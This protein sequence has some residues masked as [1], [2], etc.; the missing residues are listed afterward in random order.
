MWLYIPHKTQM[1][2]T[3]LW[4]LLPIIGVLVAWVFFTLNGDAACLG[5]ATT[6]SETTNVEIEVIAGDV[7]IGIDDTE[8]NL[9]TITASSVDETQAATFTNEFWVED[10][11]WADAGYYTTLQI[12]STGLQSATTSTDIPAANISVRTA[13]TGNAWVTVMDWTANTN[14]VVDAWMAN[15]QSLD[16]ARTFIKR[17]TAANAWLVGKYGAKPDIQVVVP[18]YTSVGNYTGVLTYTLIEN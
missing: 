10:L 9:G 2:I 12:A 13:A 11:K 15:Y 8:V 14:V 7:C 17:D 18:K 5:W 6:C 3:K 16:V 1:K 4:T